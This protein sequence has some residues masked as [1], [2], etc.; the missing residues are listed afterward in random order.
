MAT[1]HGLR[2]HRQCA[3]WLL[4]PQAALCRAGP[5]PHEALKAPVTI[6]LGLL[7]VVSV[8]SSSTLE[9]P[10]GS[11]FPLPVPHLGQGIQEA[12]RGV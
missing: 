4:T 6:G 7:Y 2:G 11:Y 8:R 12:G 1:D 10:E 9:V 5:Q 3:E